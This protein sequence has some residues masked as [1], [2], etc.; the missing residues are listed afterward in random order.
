[1]ATVVRP[2][3]LGRCVLSALDGLEGHTGSCRTSTTLRHPSLADV[4]VHPCDAELF[5]QPESAAVLHGVFAA[6]RCS[7]QFSSRTA[8]RDAGAGVDTDRDL[9]PRRAGP[10]GGNH[11]GLRVPQRRVREVA[12]AE[13]GIRIGV[14]CGSPGVHVAAGMNA[15][16][17]RDE[18]MQ[19]LNIKHPAAFH[20]TVCRDTRHRSTSK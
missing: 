9:F 6:V 5:A 4:G 7:G 14:A 16:S 19:R 2:D 20:L 11:P 8:N 10:G 3:P 18:P 13:P 17:D 1:M 15:E 12:V